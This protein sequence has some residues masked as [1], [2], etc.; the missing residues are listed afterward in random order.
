M[1]MLAFHLWN[2]SC[3]SVRQDRES[4]D[5]SSTSQTMR[6]LVLNS[7]SSSQTGPMKTRFSTIQTAITESFQSLVGPISTPLANDHVPSS[8]FTIPARF[9][10]PAPSIPS[11]RV[12]SQDSRRG[13]LPHTLSPRV[14]RAELSSFLRG[15]RVPS[16][17]RPVRSVLESHLC[18]QSFVICHWL[19]AT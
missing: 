10:C 4:Q 18:R 3:F 11:T 5:I 9:Q 7:S 2:S 14:V 1:Y 8:G 16:C 12:V 6:V 17:S 15:G 19:D 13:R